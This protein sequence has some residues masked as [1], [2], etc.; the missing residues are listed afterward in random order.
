VHLKPDYPDAHTNL[1]FSTNYHRE[2]S[3]RAIFEQHRAWGETHG[4]TRA[5]LPPAP[6]SREPQRR[7]RVGYVSPDLRGH[8]VAY[9]IEPI[10]AQHDRAHYETYCYAEIPKAKQDSTTE[11]FKALSGHWVDTCGL[12]D[13]A[14]AERVRADGIDI[15]VDLAGHTA[16]NR[17]RAFAYQ[18]APV[19]ITY[20]GY[21]NTTGMP[22]MHF[23]LTDQ[24]ADPPGQER[25]YT[26][27][28]IRLPRGFLCYAPPQDA[29]AV[30]PLPAREA[31]YVTFGSFNVLSKISPQVVALWADILGALPNAR[32]LLKNRAMTDADTREDYYRQFA[33]HGI[34]RERLE[35]IGWTVSR[36]EHLALYSR[37]DIALDTFPYHGT[38]TTCE[39]LWMGAPVIT[40]EGD[41]HA[42]RVGVSL[43]SRLGL[44]EL[45]AHEESEYMD[46]AITFAADLDRLAALRAGLRARMLG[47]GLCDGAAFTREL[48][49]VYRKLWRRWCNGV[50]DAV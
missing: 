48:E 11:R 24:W 47:S 27:E 43:L 31:G 2:L 21:A 41:R 28:L 9:F 35:M 20:L 26:E 8:S 3:A 13:R 32:L 16:N 10:L 38:T 5:G 4:R 1:L 30:S 12:S 46:K 19:Q 23:R 22:A 49:E 45:I 18:P 25:F 33:E 7:L 39:A 6:N 42:A 36:Q 40:L 44:H 29:P 37:I 15:L 17:L 14:L 50:A 34:A